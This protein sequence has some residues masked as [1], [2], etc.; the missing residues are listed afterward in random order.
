MLETTWFVIWGVLWAVYFMLDGFDF[1]VGML[2]PWLGRTDEEKRVILNSI[3]PFW[4]GNEVWLIT[5][6]GVTFAAF[7]AAYA[8]LFS[9]LYSP[10]MIILFALI[11]RAVSFEFRGKIDHPSW[12]TLF[13]AG[14]FLGSVLPAILFGVAFA[15]IFMGIPIDAEGVYHGNIFTLL[16]PYGLAGGVFFFL[17]F[18]MHGTLWIAGRSGAAF[19]ERAR[20]LSERVWV[21]LALVAVLFLV[22]TAIYTRLWENYTVLPVLLVVPAGAVASLFAERYYIKKRLLRKAFFSSAAVIG[23]SVLFG[24]LGLFPDLLPSTLNKG[25][26]LT[27]QN[28]ASTPLTLTIMLVVAVI[29]VPTVMLYQAWVYRLFHRGITTPESTAETAPEEAY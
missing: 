28:A 20:V 4:D 11:V 24:V 18:V 23:M 12:R 3:A 1:G 17:L 21:P 10:L 9:A 29:V 8:V 22:L 6:G 5:A 7:P 15:N 27:I 26:S 19:S 2:F 14:I 25:Y 16:N 13:D